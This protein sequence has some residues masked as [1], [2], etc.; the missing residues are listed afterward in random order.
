[1]KVCIRIYQNDSG[2]FTASCPMLPGCVCHGP[3]KEEVQKRL[4]EAITGYVA[5]LNDFVP[6]QVTHEVVEV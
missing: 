6:H 3:T 2:G 5:A 4:D 1:M